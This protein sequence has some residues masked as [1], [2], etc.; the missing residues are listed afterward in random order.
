M[1]RYLKNAA[2]KKV[3]IDAVIYLEVEKYTGNVAASLEV[4]GPQIQWN[5]PQNAKKI[6]D[7][8]KK[9][10]LSTVVENALQSIDRFG[11]PIIKSKQQGYYS[12]YIQFSPCN[13]QNHR[14]MPDIELRV[15]ISDHVANGSNVSAKDIK[16]VFIKSFV[17]G[18]VTYS[19]AFN[20]I[21]A[22]DRMCENLS[23]GNLDDLINYIPELKF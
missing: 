5:D 2:S 22:I 7:D 12:W 9:S 16:K 20:A 21:M 23:N 14:D 4:Q 15:R 8:A 3:V 18:D 6:I 11:F 19:S 17:L 13:G 1:K 10:I